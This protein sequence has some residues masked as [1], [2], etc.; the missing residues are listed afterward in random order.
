METY[1][2]HA[3]EIALQVIPID[4]IIRAEEFI[5]KRKENKGMLH[6]SQENLPYLHGQQMFH[7]T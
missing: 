6:I 4:S 7:T 3:A 2:D 5:L 1:N